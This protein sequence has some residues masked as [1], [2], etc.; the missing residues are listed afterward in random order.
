MLKH[1]SWAMTLI[2]DIDSLLR[3]LNW[4]RIRQRRALLFLL[5]GIRDVARTS[6]HPR[7][8]CLQIKTFCL[9]EGRKKKKKRQDDLAPAAAEA[10]Q[11]GFEH[12]STSSIALLSV[13]HPADFAGG[14]FSQACWSATFVC[15]ANLFSQEAFLVSFTHG[16]LRSTKTNRPGQPENWYAVY[17]SAQIWLVYGKA[18]KRFLKAFSSRSGPLN[19]S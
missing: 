3:R 7:H 10:L 17:R 9:Q 12:L 1:N 4:Q 16:E 5:A 15:P 19:T 18:Q 13:Q 11:L 6:W 14:K 2:S 8:K